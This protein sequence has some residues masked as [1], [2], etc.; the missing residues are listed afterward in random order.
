MSLA[1]DWKCYVHNWTVNKFCDST[2]DFRFRFSAEKGISFSF[3]AENENWIFGRPLHQTVSHYTL[4]Q[5]FSNIQQSWFRTACMCLENC[6]TLHFWHKSFILH[7][8][9]HHHRRVV[10][11]NHCA[12]ALLPLTI[13]DLHSVERWHPPKLSWTRRCEGNPA[14]MPSRTCIL[15]DWSDNSLMRPK[16]IRSS[17]T[18]P[19]R[20]NFFKNQSRLAAFDVITACMIIPLRRRVDGDSQKFIFW[21][22]LNRLSRYQQWR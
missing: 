6:F 17:L 1:L 4:R 7:H 12:R 14:R 19:A 16:Y 11:V 9:Q 3:T 2:G 18:T 21:H 10:R 15:Q 8:H 5:W 13:S 20:F 22:P